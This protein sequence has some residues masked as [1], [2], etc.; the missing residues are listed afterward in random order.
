MEAAPDPAVFVVKKTWCC[1]GSLALLQTAVIK[2]IIVFTP[3][4]R[5]STQQRRNDGARLNPAVSDR[6]GCTGPA[7]E[8]VLIASPQET[9]QVS[10]GE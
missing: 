6:A 8:R 4:P 7:G 10:D 3:E 9:F 1:G 5:G 2:G